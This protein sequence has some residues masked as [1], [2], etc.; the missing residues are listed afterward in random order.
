MEGL[1]LLI[2]CIV[3]S[4]V[5]SALVSIVVMSAFTTQIL[6]FVEEQTDLWAKRFEQ[7]TTEILTKTGVLK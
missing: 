4:F 6:K 2:I 1:T 5:I 7:T 3:F